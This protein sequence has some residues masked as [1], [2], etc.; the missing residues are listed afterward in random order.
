[1]NK[2]RATLEEV[3]S[4]IASVQAE[5]DQLQAKA[6][7][8][9]L[10]P[11]ETAKYEE[12]VSS[13]EALKNDESQLSAEQRYAALKLKDNSPRNPAPKVYAS[14]KREEKRMSHDE[15]M[16]LWFKG[17]FK[18]HTLTQEDI[19]RAR[20]AGFDILG[21]TLRFEVNYNALN[22]KVKAFQKRTKLSTGGAGSGAEWLYT[23]YSD[24]VVEFLSYESSFVNMLD[25]VTVSGNEHV[26]YKVDNTSLES[27]FTSA[28]GGSETNPTINEQN[29]TSAKSTVKLFPITSGYHKVT[30]EELQDAY[31]DIPSQISK[32]NALMHKRKIENEV[33]LATGNGANGVQGLIDVAAT[34]APSASAFDE[35]AI[36]GLYRSIPLPY[37]GNVIFVGNDDTAKQIY[38]EAV[39]DYGRSLFDRNIEDGI[40]FETLIGKKFFVSEKVPDDMLLCFAPEYYKLVM[41]NVETFQFLEEK[42]FPDSAWSG[43]MRFGGVWTGPTAAIQ[44]LELGS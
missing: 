13:L 33:V 30:W 3:Q 28:G 25:V 11:E 18:P 5:L 27:A 42:F 22:H 17:R 12:L 32:A 34:D 6:D 23:T 8:E 37:R 36:R 7:S 26:V 31:I 35:I 40:E 21:N 38:D 20:S 14:A 4:Q 41:G 10:T 1:M 15:A 39:D 29:L 24:K 19:Y 16:R 43:L 2:V 9:G 44:V